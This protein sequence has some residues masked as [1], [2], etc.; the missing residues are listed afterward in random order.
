[1]KDQELLANIVQSSMLDQ[2]FLEASGI[3]SK[4]MQER[5][6]REDFIEM[7]YEIDDIVDEAGRFH[8][9]DVLNICK[10][11]VPE[12]SKTP[13]DGWLEH[14][15]LYYLHLIFPHLDGPADSRAFMHGRNIFMQILRGVYAYERIEAPFDPLYDIHLLSEQEIKKYMYTSEYLTLREL[16]TD[17]FVYEFMRL[18]N[19][20]IPGKILGYVGA[21][22][23]LALYTGRQLR[24]AGYDID[25]GLLS[26]AAATHEIGKYGC[27]PGE[28][29]RAPKL[30][31][32]YTD[33]CLSR[34]NMPT[35][36]NI[37]VHH[38]LWNLELENLSV[39]S[40]LLVYAY[41]RVKITNLG[42]NLE[43]ISFYT[44]DEAFVDLFDKLGEISGDDKTRYLRVYHK[45]HDFEEFME[46]SGV[47]TEIPVNFSER[48]ETSEDKV[49]SRYSYDTLIKDAFVKQIKFCTIEHNI[50]MM[51]LF[52]KKEYFDMLI[53]SARIESE[54]G[55]ISTYLSIFGEY[56]TYMTEP[57]KTAV[58]DF[59]YSTLGHAES[60]LR[61]QSAH[62]MGTIVASYRREYKKE[63]PKSVP[64]PDT[65]ST[66]VDIF[67]KYLRKI[68]EPSSAISQEE[69]YHIIKA[70]PAFVH[71][72]LKYCQP[73]KRH[74]Y[75]E[76]LN[77]YFSNNDLDHDTIIALGC[78]AMVINPDFLTDDFRD[79][80]MFFAKNMLGSLDK[81]S[82][83]LALVI[84]EKFFGDSSI[85]VKQR[86]LSVLELPSLEDLDINGLRE[87]T[88]TNMDASRSWLIRYSVIDYL[89]QAA[90]MG[91]SPFEIA[92]HLSKIIINDK[93][94]L[95]RRHAG[96]TLVDISEKMSKSEINIICISLFTALE[97]GDGQYSRILPKYL[98]I[99]MLKLED[100][101][102]YALLD[103]LEQIVDSFDTNNVATANAA[104]NTVG[105]LLERYTAYRAD[106][107]N[108]FRPKLIHI[109]VKGASKK[110][111]L[112]SKE[113]VRVLGLRTFGS[114]IM[115]CDDKKW[116]KANFL[117]SIASIFPQHG[118]DGGLEFYNNATVLN[119]IYRFI[120]IAD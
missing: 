86:R 102:F 15:R 85:N 106:Y 21:V 89:K 94:V 117:R 92:R 45:L 104:I 17:N 46:A 4:T 41:A 62:L 119:K 39:E 35:I 34:Y 11:Y 22:H 24:E 109:L 67:E 99:L 108:D 52:N 10:K 12:L 120:N 70:L 51:K 36:M 40:L 112:V 95:L 68:V 78:T 55:N 75:L 107:D 98:A 3:S 69:Y 56:S 19:D 47:V 82:V 53:D 118:E 115:S 83:A 31:Y 103:F 80:L 42:N 29:H 25:L 116:I 57:Q 44:L 61:N 33:Y 8:S 32:Y 74:L 28:E 49:L 23:Y 64:A 65:V 81:G 13:K 14:C 9:G 1:M 76:I 59:M 16:V 7:I 101:E 97:S 37:A 60:D 88:S 77:D 18:S 105:V 6:A 87:I 73:S 26:A 48:P 38:S 90:L 79:T 71:E 30:H 5:I 2:K 96:N 20:L 72:V 114:E 66:N 63:L 50:R 110:D 54:H 84:I 93:T 27:R 100:N 43:D 113:A 91:F 58:L 111:A